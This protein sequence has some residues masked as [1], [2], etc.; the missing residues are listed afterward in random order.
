MPHVFKEL[1]V[2]HLQIHQGLLNSVCTWNCFNIFIALIKDK[3]MLF[4]YQLLILR[5]IMYMK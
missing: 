4:E 3:T 1:Q 2:N 5:K